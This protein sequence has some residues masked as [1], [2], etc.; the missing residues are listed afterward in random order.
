MAHIPGATLIPMA[1]VSQ[2]I[3]EIDPNRPVVVH[4]AVGARSAKIVEDL[5]RAGYTQV[6]NMAGG[7]MEWSNRQLPT[8]TG[9]GQR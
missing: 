6:F 4:C 2:R 7:I 3:S 8:E 9:D 5:R 1:E